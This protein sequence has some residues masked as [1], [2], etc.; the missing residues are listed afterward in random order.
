[1]DRSVRLSRMTGEV[2]ASQRR[3]AP[4]ARDVAPSITLIFTQRET[5]ISPLSTERSNFRPFRALLSV[6][7]L[8]LM[9]QFFSGGRAYADEVPTQDPIP[10][11]PVVEPTQVLGLLPT[12]VAAPET[13]T[14]VPPTLPPDPPTAT[15][16]PEVIEAAT[17][18]STVPV[19]TATPVVIPTSAQPVAG[20]GTP[21]WPV[22]TPTPVPPTNTATAIPT[23]T[24][25]SLPATPT[26]TATATSSWLPPGPECAPKPGKTLLKLDVP[27]I[28]QVNDVSGADG[29][30]ACGP[31]SVLMVLAYFGK[32]EPWPEYQAAL[33]TG[34]ITVTA[35]ARSAQA[36]S[37]MHIDSAEVGEKSSF[38][39]YL[40]NAYTLG[41]H[42]YSR[43]APD[44]LGNRVAGLYG[45]ICPT[46][47]AD[48]GLMSQVLDWNGLGSRQISATWENV[49]A[50]LKKGHPVLLGN[51][52]TSVGHILVATGYTDNK[53]L[54]VNDPYG[55]RFKTGYGANDGEGV[56]YSWN[57]SRVR[58]AL[59]VIGV[60]T[61]PATPTATATAT[62]P[63][64]ATP[65]AALPTADTATATPTHGTRAP[66][67]NA[68]TSRGGTHPLPDNKLSERQPVVREQP[69]H[70]RLAAAQHSSTLPAYMWLAIPTLA[71]LFGFALLFFSRRS[72]G[73]A[74]EQTNSP[75][76]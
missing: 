3:V 53:Y 27:Y 30:W 10:P 48:W 65:A 60:Y 54:V 73:K 4:Q 17:A 68:P 28:H 1:M 72:T 75:P 9:L 21:F 58:N 57:C 47:L 44:P 63:A 74:E 55:N 61:P 20:I 6:F 46:G 52:L 19:E 64:T 31:T 24:A 12:L 37:P 25:T 22:N 39:P 13:P 36:S 67:A 69:G 29:N 38:A 2:G 71:A 66:A 8:G 18:T 11:V 45:A 16:T 26:A 7:A 42:T 14:P 23:S 51:D 50:A 49:V 33:A 62:T 43:T 70:V 34:T 32:V 56:Y 5:T 76:D 41:G 35:T 59:E 40:T 15:S